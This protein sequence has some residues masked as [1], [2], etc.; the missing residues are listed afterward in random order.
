M[1]VGT[2]NE[3]TVII[4]SNQQKRTMTQTRSV[5]VEFW[6][7]YPEVVKHK[8]PNDYKNMNK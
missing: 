3:K 4:K 5:L 6:L 1:E 2:S 8:R 7:E